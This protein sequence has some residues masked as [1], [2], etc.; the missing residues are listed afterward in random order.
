MT[1]LE[2]EQNIRIGHEAIPFQLF[3]GRA[4][5][6][7]LS[8]AD[9]NL[10]Q[11][12]TGTGKLA[13]FDRQFLATKSKWILQ[14]YRTRR[15]AENRKR[16]LLVEVEKRILLFGKDTEVQFIPDTKTYFKYSPDGV[17]IVHAPAHIIRAH[18]K[19]VLYFALR[20]F[21]ELYLNQK[22]AQWAKATGM[23]YK[24]IVVKD[25]RSKWGSCST[26]SNINLNWHLVLLKESLIDYV[27]VHEL[28]HLHEMNHSPAFWA[29]VGKYCPNYKQLRKQLK[30]QQ[31]LVGI[32]N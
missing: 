10:L 21:S 11:I 17:F 24:R 2:A 20:K 15:D 28:M 25:L 27:V 18:K 23:S 19:K 8:F 12:E 13:E 26:L 9:G 31:W 3:K 7:R 32:L 22:T 29:W 30:E 5:R 6:I 14:G 16:E 1:I 4:N